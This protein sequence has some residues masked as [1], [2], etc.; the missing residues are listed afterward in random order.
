MAS[1][2]VL[3]PSHR[4]HNVLDVLIVGGGPA[5][6]SAALSLGRVLRSVALFDSKQYRNAP[7]SQAHNLPLHDG[8][9]PA[10]IRR[11]MKE[12][13]QQK[14]KTI[15]FVEA[16]A[17]TASEVDGIFHIVDT[18]GTTWKGRKLILATGKQDILPDIPGFKESWGKGMWVT[19]SSIKGARLMTIQSSLPILPVLRGGGCRYIPDRLSDRK[20]YIRR[21]H[22]GI[23]LLHATP[24]PLHTATDD[25]AQRSRHRAYSWKTRGDCPVARIPNRRATDRQLRVRGTNGADDGQIL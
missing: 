22:P 7:S 15:T 1:A 3:A 10:D 4:L 20:R 16:G 18:S 5:G 14:Y 13:I 6:L 8:E 24:L 12:E 23:R 11:R 25:P 19:S 21:H 2:D 17:S 9:N